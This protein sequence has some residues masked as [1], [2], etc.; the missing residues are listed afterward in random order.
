MR[1]MKTLQLED[2]RGPEGETQEA[3]KITPETG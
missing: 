1:F 2:L 3:K